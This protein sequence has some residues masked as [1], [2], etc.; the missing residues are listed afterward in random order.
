MKQLWPTSGTLAD[1]RSKMTRLKPRSCSTKASTSD[2]LS[3]AASCARSE[4]ETH[5]MTIYEKRKTGRKIIN[6]DCNLISFSTFGSPSVS[7]PED[8]HRLGNLA[9]ISLCVMKD[10]TKSQPGVMSQSAL[11]SDPPSSL[12]HWLTRAITALSS[13]ASSIFM[14]SVSASAA[15]SARTARSW[16]A[17]R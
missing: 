11:S 9:R 14:A 8:V 2:W 1:A 16:L 6:T 5:L 10:W 7:T 13:R 12:T 15:T 3:V 4:P 17:F